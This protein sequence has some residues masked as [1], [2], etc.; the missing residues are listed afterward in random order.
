MVLDEMRPSYKLAIGVIATI[1]VF[2]LTFYFASRFFGLN[3]WSELQAPEWFLILVLPSGIALLF[4]TL[5]GGNFISTKKAAIVATLCLL[6]ISPIGWWHF[7]GANFWQGQEG[8]MSGGGDNQ[9]ENQAPEEQRQGT[10]FKYQASF[11]YLSSEDNGPIDSKL[12]IVFPAP[13]INNKATVEMVAGPSSDLENVMWQLVAHYENNEEDWMQ[14]E[15][16][17]NIPGEFVY[18]RKDVPLDSSPYLDNTSH[19][20]KIWNELTTWGDNAFYQGEESLIE[21]EFLV[22]NEKADEVT[23]VDNWGGVYAGVDAYF[24]KDEGYKRIIGS[25][26]VN[27]SKEVEG[28]YVSLESYKITEKNMGT[29]DNWWK[30]LNSV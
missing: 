18:P 20:P 1:V 7:G 21:V 8:G 30:S 14:V 3:I 26:K 9:L 23:L 2:T 22:P 24:G 28:K 5:T 29:L 25:F 6:V 16:E 11:R 12:F 15:M 19:G 27:L 17:N 13:N 10:L 4:G